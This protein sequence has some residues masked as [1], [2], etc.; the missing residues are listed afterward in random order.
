MKTKHR[1]ASAI[2]HVWAA[3]LALA[4]QHAAK[5]PNIIRDAAG[6]FAYYADYDRTYWKTESG[7]SW[8]TRF[9]PLNRPNIIH[10]IPVSMERDER[11]TY[12]ST[13]HGSGYVREA[14]LNQL[15]SPA[16]T[17]F[18][19]ATI[20]LRLNDWV[21]QVRSAAARC[22]ARI[23]PDTPAPI[24][25]EAIV[26]IL[27]VSKDWG[28]WQRKQDVLDNLITRQDVAKELAILIA[29]ATTGPSTR[30]L[31]RILKT[32]ALDEELLNL[33]HAAN[34]PDVRAAALTVL[35]DGMARIET[36]KKQQWISKVDGR[37][38]IEPVITERRIAINVDQLHLIRAAVVSNYA[39][40]R[41]AALNGLIRHFL[42][43]DD[44]K[45]I[46]QLLLTD[47]SPTNQQKA[48]FIC[49]R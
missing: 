49:N 26:S 28:R 8:W 35:L 43:T 20:L 29:N 11:I 45:Q 24:V 13:L 15:T 17:P 38:H 10:I 9:N 1:N 3:I 23:T 5:A 12:L 48:A 34:Q 6:L 32:S 27:I 37:Y 40:V 41:K 33:F 7:N 21:P 44:A 14:A 4:P 42:D 36:G 31:N 2:D 46:A 22:I 18:I 39:H 47:K 25:A 30:L 16:A 19:L